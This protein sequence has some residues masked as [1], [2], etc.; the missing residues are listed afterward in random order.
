MMKPITQGLSMEARVSL[1]M[2]EIVLGDRQLHCPYLW[3]F[4]NRKAASGL[5]CWL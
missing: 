4:A 3:A 1:C 5:L 2:C